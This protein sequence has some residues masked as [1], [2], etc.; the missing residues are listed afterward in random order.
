MSKKNKMKGGEERRSGM[1]EEPGI[2]PLA[3]WMGF[4][5]NL[6][7]TTGGARKVQACQL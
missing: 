6:G 1:P 7:E 2:G 3:G 4:C 5:K